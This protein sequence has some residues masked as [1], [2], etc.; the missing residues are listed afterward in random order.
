[1]TGRRA[2][3]SAPSPDACVPHVRG[4][5]RVVALVKDLLR[6]HSA[7]DFTT[8]RTVRVHRHPD[9]A[10]HLSI[11]LTSIVTPLALSR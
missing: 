1:M 6:S 5:V 10:A 11:P 4:V 3:T 9:T 7:G 8:P 2:I